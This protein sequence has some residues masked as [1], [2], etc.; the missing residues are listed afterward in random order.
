LTPL[1][2]SPTPAP[3]PTASWSAYV[4]S[5]YKFSIQYPS[6][7]ISANL[8][9]QDPT[10]PMYVSFNPPGVPSSA[11]SITLAYANRTYQ[12]A[13][14]MNATAGTTISVASVSATQKLLTNSDGVTTIQVIVPFNN[15]A[16]I[17]FNAAQQYQKIFKQMLS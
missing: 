1:A 10:T 7:W 12:N 9:E 5:Q 11:L 8:G 3:D 13:L 15:N 6:N 16:T 2:L 4:S 14:S 17:I